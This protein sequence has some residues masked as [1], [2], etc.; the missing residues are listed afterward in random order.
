M[1]EDISSPIVRVLAPI[2]E[3]SMSMIKPAFMRLII[4]LLGALLLLII[5]IKDK[6]TPELWYICYI[7]FIVI[8]FIL[9]LLAFSL[10]YIQLKLRYS[11]RTGEQL[12]KA[13]REAVTALQELQ[14][15]K[16][17]RL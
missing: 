12:K 2:F 11:Q 14:K 3:K 17:G 10:E 5:I 16:T 9:A 15:K 6:I 7:L 4:F 8:I 1:K 13:L